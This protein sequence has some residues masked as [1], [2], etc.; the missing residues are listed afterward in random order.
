M[1][2]LGRCPLPSTLKKPCRRWEK[3]ERSENQRQHA[4]DPRVEL[5][6]IPW[7]HKYFG[8]YWR[9]CRCLKPF[10][11]DDKNF[12]PKKGV[13]R[14]KEIDQHQVYLRFRRVCLRRAFQSCLVR[15]LFLHVA[16]TILITACVYALRWSLLFSF[17][18]CL[19]FSHQKQHAQTRTVSVQIKVCVYITGRTSNTYCCCKKHAKRRQRHEAQKQTCATAA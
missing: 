4:N 6:H 11:S 5:K 12:V 2:T 13:C 14:L 15:T 19:S 9:F 3:D 17:C 18:L 8:P 10:H 16:R 7:Y 1:G